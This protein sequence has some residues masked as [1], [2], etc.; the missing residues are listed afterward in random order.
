[1]KQLICTLVFLRNDT[2]LLL[3]LKKRGFGAG[4]WLGAGGKVD[5][6][7]TVEQAMIRECREEIGVT[8][9]QYR[10]MAVLLYDE[11]FKQQRENIE[12]HIYIASSWTGEPV[13]TDEMNP[14]WFHT[15]Q[16]PYDKMLPDDTYWLPELLS[17]K[18]LRGQF[19]LNQAGEVASHSLSEVCLDE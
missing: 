5:P 8:P 2:Q 16:I 3:A 7:E 11:Y 15:K 18:Q 14:R 12:V 1:M 13:E 4:K 19:V 17:G 10:K 6:G 9:T